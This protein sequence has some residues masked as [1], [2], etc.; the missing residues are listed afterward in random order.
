MSS[1]HVI[2]SHLYLGWTT[3]FSDISFVNVVLRGRFHQPYDGV[4]ED[5][6]GS[7]TGV[8]RSVLLAPDELTHNRTSCTS[9]PFFDNALRCSVD[10]GS[11]LRFEYVESVNRTFLFVSNTYNRSTTLS[12]SNDPYSNPHGYTLVLQANQTYRL[13]FSSTNVMNMIFIMDLRLIDDSF[14]LLRIGSVLTTTC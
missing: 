12:Y 11:W 5:L 2:V 6:D 10:Q 1:H 7:L 13:S 4:Y 14:F 9:T 3:K 8:N